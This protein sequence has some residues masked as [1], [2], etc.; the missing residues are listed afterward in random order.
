M[1]KITLASTAVL[2]AMLVLLLHAAPVQATSTRTWVASNG[3]NNVTCG[4]TNPCQTFQQAHDVTTAG[5]EINCVDAG[6]YGTV[7]INRSI[8]IICDNTEAGI[9]ATSSVGISVNDSASATPGTAIVTLKGID[10]DGGI[11]GTVGINF[12]GGAVL[13]VHKVLIKKFGGSGIALQANGYAELYV[14]D[15]SITDNGTAGIGG[16]IVIRQTGTGSANAFINRV[17]LE[18]NLVGI[19]VDGTQ[20]TGVGINAVVLDS[21]VSGSAGNGITA[22]TSA[23]HAAVS[24]VVDG[25]KIA[26]NFGSGINAN[27]AAASGVGSA[28]VRVGGSSIVNNVTGASA[29][30]AGPGVLQSFKNNKISGNLADGTPITAFPGPGGPPLQ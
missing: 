21:V 2:G 7:T 15:S 9:L 4:R 5:G 14:A 22:T 6:D 8:S 23:A 10:I 20:S 24:V 12:Q 25:T 13:H 11:T 29:T 1:R 18:N 19:L 27:G 30:G 28:I 26:G 16:G 3:T 17:K